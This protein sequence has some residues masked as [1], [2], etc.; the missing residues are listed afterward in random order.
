MRGMRG[1]RHRIGRRDA[2]GIERLARQ[3]E[4]AEAGVLVDVA[5]DIGQL[6]RAA[7]MMRQR[8]AV[9]LA[10]AE[11]AHRQAADRRGDAVA[12][13]IELIEARRAD[14]LDRVH[15]HAVDDGEEV[16]LAQAELP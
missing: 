7:E 13:E 12:I 10:H 1:D 3:I 9:L 4:P 11:H 6:Q 14:V 8:D 5:Q 15:L 2:G 16:L